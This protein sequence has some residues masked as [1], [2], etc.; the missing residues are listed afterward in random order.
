MSDSICHGSLTLGCSLLPL[1]Q[2]C[3]NFLY[4]ANTVTPAF[5][6]SDHKLENYSD[7]L[8]PHKKT[9]MQEHKISE[10]GKC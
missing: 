5:L 3:L 9:K 2:F 8:K 6:N 7:W 10:L 4:R 1:Q